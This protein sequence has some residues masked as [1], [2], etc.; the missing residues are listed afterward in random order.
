VQLPVLGSGHFV[1]HTLEAVEA[2]LAAGKGHC[3]HG[4]MAQPLD[5]I[6]GAAA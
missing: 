2:T 3:S 4:E 5:A 6:D 1:G